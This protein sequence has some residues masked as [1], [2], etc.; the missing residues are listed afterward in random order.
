MFLQLIN[1]ET[2]YTIALS[3]IYFVYNLYF[4]YLFRAALC[5]PLLELCKVFCSISNWLMLQKIWGKRGLLVFLRLS[6]V[7]PISVAGNGGIWTLNL[8]FMGRV[9]YHCA[10]WARIFSHVQPIYERVVID[11][12]PQRYMH[13]PWTNLSEQDETWAEFTTLSWGMLLYM[14]CNCIQNKLA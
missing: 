13:R 9:F 4:V 3:L 7:S 1:Y 2:F 10:T 6:I 14:P 12:D 5:R 8:R 11:L